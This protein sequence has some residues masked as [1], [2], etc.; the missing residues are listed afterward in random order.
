MSAADV[1]GVMERHAPWQK[2]AEVASTDLPPDVG[3][4][5]HPLGSCSDIRGL[6]DSYACF[7][8][9]RVGASE[10]LRRKFAFAFWRSR[11]LR[12]LIEDLPR[13]PAARRQD[14]LATLGELRTYIAPA[15]RRQLLGTIDD[16]EPLSALLA[17]QGVRVRGLHDDLD[18]PG[19][20]VDI[21]IRAN[22]SSS[23]TFEKWSKIEEFGRYHFV[24]DGVRYRGL[25]FRPGDILLSNCNL[26]G[27]G[28]Y[29]VLSDPRN[30]S[31]HSAVFAILPGARGR[32][33]VVVETYEKGL[34]AVPLSVF[35]SP[36]FSAYTE[37]YRHKR[38]QTE[39]TDRA[40]RTAFRM[41][42]EIRGYN[43]DTEDRDAC[44]ISCTGVGR[45]L[46]EA[47]GLG[48]LQRISHLGHPRIQDNLGRLGYRFFE[49]F[50]PV[51]FLL[52]AALSC[53]GWID[54]DQVDRLLA[55][56]LVELRFRT[57]FA[58]RE[59]NPRRFPLRYA[60]NRWGIRQLRQR[61]TI[62]SL[63]SWVEGFDH[64][65]LP[66]GPDPVIALI[67]LAEA[68]VGRAIAR[69]H[70]RVRDHLKDLTRLD[71]EEVSANGALRQVI[72]DRLRLPWL[73]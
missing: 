17:Q 60:I 58:E 11:L 34:R 20:Q 13:H 50:A 44:Y 7:E 26:D 67:T 16:R 28:I 22:R 18:L 24:E 54:N 56:E 69:I 61:T 27:N 25:L 66:K 23:W 35:L 49:M 1:F 53:V 63:V 5:A 52:N 46:L 12:R 8:R 30:F 36:R 3:E 9:W 32:F 68:Q 21:G 40:N 10:T 72:E 2:G 57:R 14:R 55:R 59:I 38:L 19:P 47:I 48:R 42:R 71:L 64:V 37:V 4:P 45:F 41:L 70:P 29:T 65:N 15:L 31:S 43:F 39:H 6:N 62:G 73:Q 33:P 51:D